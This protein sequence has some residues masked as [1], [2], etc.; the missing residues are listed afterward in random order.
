MTTLEGG[1]PIISQKRKLRLWGIAE[2]VQVINQ[3]RTGL[4][5]PG[6]TPKSDMAQWPCYKTIL[7]LVPTPCLSEALIRVGQRNSGS[8]TPLEFLDAISTELQEI[9]A[10]SI[11]WQ[12]HSRPTC[13]IVMAFCSLPCSPLKCYQVP[14]IL[15]LKK[16]VHHEKLSQ[17]PAIPMRWESFLVP[18][19]QVSKIKYNKVTSSQTWGLQGPHL[20]RISCSFHFSFSWRLCILFYTL[21]S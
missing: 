6:P 21:G 3:A 7:V 13:L 20:G 19:F 8:E 12:C 11:Y 18:Y 4:L 15:S 17:S 9:M 1:F 10:H 14:V 2:P 5:D 16:S